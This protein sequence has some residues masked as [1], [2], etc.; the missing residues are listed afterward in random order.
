MAGIHT[1]ISKRPA[2]QLLAV[3]QVAPAVHATTD[4]DKGTQDMPYQCWQ[5]PSTKQYL[6]T[7][8]HIRAD[9]MLQLPCLAR[10]SL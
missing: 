10:T 8:V 5:T 7:I 3:T 4:T 1:P 9:R 2:L 6:S